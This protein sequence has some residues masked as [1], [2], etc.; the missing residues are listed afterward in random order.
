M[1]RPHNKPAVAVHGM[2]EEPDEAWEG[3]VKG[4]PLADHAG[5]PPAERSTGLRVAE[6]HAGSGAGHSSS[7][8]PTSRPCSSAISSRTGDVSESSTVQPQAIAF[9]NDLEVTN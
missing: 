9:S 7:Q 4:I 5:R 8:K 6:D 1:C 3:H 2:L